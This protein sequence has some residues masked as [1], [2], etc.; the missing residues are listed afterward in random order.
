MWLLALALLLTLATAIV[1]WRARWN[2]QHVPTL[3]SVQ[4]GS[5]TTISLIIPARNEA[6]NLRGLLPTCLAQTQAPSELIV[7]DDQS[8]DATAAVATAFG[9]QVLAITQL[10]DGWTGKAHACHSGALH[11]RGD[12]LLF[13]DADVRLEPSAI[14]AACG[15][16]TADGLV[17][18]SLLLR[19]RCQ[20]WQECLLIP[21]AYAQYFVGAPVGA[22]FQIEKPQAI[23][24]GQFFLIQRAAYLASGGFARVRHAVMEDLAIARE[25]KHDGLRI[26][27]AHGE[28]LAQVRMYRSFGELWQGFAKTS[29]AS[30]AY[31]PHGGL[32]T[33]VALV[34]LSMILPVLVAAI[35]ESNLAALCAALAAYALATL[36][37]SRW[38]QRYAVSPIYALLYP[39]AATLML[40]IALSATA[41]RW[42]G[43]GVL[44]KG[45]ILEARL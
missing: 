4:D 37:I 36:H 19:Q 42:S 33:I 18:L 10:P 16:A 12:W 39:L 30:L 22:H 11:A 32:W 2:D 29:I 38:T 34:A 20:S 23:V 6:E 5:H 8:T 35:A 43:R 14:A 15:A 26:G 9:A 3:K 31:D 7:V 44:W 41:R 1:A 17:S 21:F 45:R 27:F 24:N 25:L 28:T 13:L 40:L